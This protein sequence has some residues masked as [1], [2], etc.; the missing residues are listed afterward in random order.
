MCLSALDTFAFVVFSRS[1][2]AFAQIKELYSASTTCL[3]KVSKIP[4]VEC[5]VGHF[6]MCGI[7]VGHT[8]IDITKKWCCA[9]TK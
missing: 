6:C 2:A 4:T 8:I 5:A 3:N 9:F 1:T 7:Q